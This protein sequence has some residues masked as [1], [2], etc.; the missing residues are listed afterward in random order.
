MT[1]RFRI[2]KGVIN[3][4][5]IEELHRLNDL[6]YS[7]KQEEIKLKEDFKKKEAKLKIREQE[8][9]A[10]EKEFQELLEKEC[11][12]L[13]YTSP[14]T[15]VIFKNNQ[16]SEIQL[17]NAKFEVLNEEL[18]NEIKEEQFDLALEK[19]ALTPRRELRKIIKAKKSTM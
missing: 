13:A 11:D 1:D 10:K 9:E 18:L 8:L 5:P 15:E 12:V 17:T 7:L 6:A 19:L 16:L 3:N 14:I 2:E 4:I